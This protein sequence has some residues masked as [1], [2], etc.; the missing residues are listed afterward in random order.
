MVRS[1][2]IQ[3]EAVTAIQ[4]AGGSVSYDWQWIPGDHWGSSV[5]PPGGKPW[6]P[7]WLVNLIGVDYFGHVTL[8]VLCDSP[9]ATETTIAHVGVQ[10]AAEKKSTI[11]R[12]TVAQTC[13]RDR[14][15]SEE[16]HV[17]TSRAHDPAGSAFSMAV[18][19]Y[20]FSNQAL[21]DRFRAR[22]TRLD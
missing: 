3:R 7:Q 10:I 4:D 18:L 15:F 2:R 6:A 16:C 14:W 17:F 21:G 5:S 11:F 13:S 12:T 19:E 20:E 8:V 22:K 1:A 9:A